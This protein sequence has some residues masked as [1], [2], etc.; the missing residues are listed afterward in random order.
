MK[1]VLQLLA[2]IVLIPLGLT[3]EASVAAKIHK[4]RSL[5]DS[6][7]LLKGDNKS[8]ENESNKL[9]SGFLSML[10][11][12]SDESLLVSLFLGLVM[13]YTKLNRI[14]NAASFFDL[15]QNTKVLAK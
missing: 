6:E 4:K 10:L 11:G 3:T 12:T 1:N 8:I 9:R 15:F 14:F 5:E 2:K 13:E 7:L